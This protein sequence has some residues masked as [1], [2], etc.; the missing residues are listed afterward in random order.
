M[1]LTRFKTNLSQDWIMKTVEK[2][3]LGFALSFA[4]VAGAQA[5]SNVSAGATS[6]TNANSG[7]QASNTGVQMS[8]TWNT[9]G[10]TNSH[11]H[12]SGVT[13]S[14][15]AVGLG[16][17]SSSFSSD[18]CGGVSQTGLSAP[19][20]TLAH[21]DPVLGDPGVA[22]VLTRA[23][24][25]T[26]EYSATFGN[27][28][29][30]AI[31]LADEADKRKD[32]SEAAEYRNAAYSYAQTSGKLAQAAVNM[33]C[34]LSPDIRSAYIDAGVSCPETDAEKSAK[35]AKAA[36]EVKQEA[37]ARGEPTDPLVRHRMGLQPLSVASK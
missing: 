21:G 20:V 36:E 24:V 30:K 22:C 4:L 1:R 8:N 10:D 17:F 26:M 12:Y 11:I 18:Y 25:H 6:T 15:T 7:S 34:K 19:Y 37:V 23:S 13:G 28:A 31:A 29:A 5:Q 3:A 2:F 9:P 16:S 33:L 32:A 14:N 27:A 35:S